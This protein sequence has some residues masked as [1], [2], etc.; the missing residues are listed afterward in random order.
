MWLPPVIRNTWCS[1]QWTIC[2]VYNLI[3]WKISTLQ[4]YCAFVGI[5]FSITR[6]INTAW[7]VQFKV[8]NFSV[9]NMQRKVWLG[10]SVS[11]T[12]GHQTPPCSSSCCCNTPNFPARLL[13]CCFN[14]R[15]NIK[16]DQMHRRSGEICNGLKCLCFFLLPRSEYEIPIWQYPPSLTFVFIFILLDIKREAANHLDERFWM[17][18]FILYDCPSSWW[19]WWFHH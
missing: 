19:C 1:V 7:N 5:L 12:D 17:S 18:R 16:L 2:K 6:E 8:F 10:P 15:E 13:L 14:S 3:L 9:C 11:R 4:M